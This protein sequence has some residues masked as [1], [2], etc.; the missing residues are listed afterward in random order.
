M[1][2]AIIGAS[3]FLASYLID[4]LGQGHTLTLFSRTTPGVGHAFVPF[5]VPEQPLDPATLLGQDVVIYCAAAGVQAKTPEEKSITQEVNAVLP[6]RLLAYLEEHKWQGKWISF[7]SFW[8]IGTN[9][10]MRGFTEEEIVRSERPVPNLYC[11][12]KRMLSQ[13]IALPSVGV[14]AYHL[15][16][17]TI[18]G[19]RENPNRFIPY[20]IRSLQEGTTPKLSAG[21]QVREYIHATD[22]ASL[23]D[24]IVTGSYPAGIY[25]ASNGERFKMADVAQL[26]FGLFEQ[27]ATPALG[28][29]ETRDESMPVLLLNYD[30]V[31]S[32]IPEWNA[33]VSLKK[34]IKEYLVKEAVSA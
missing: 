24:I 19:V 15:I 7:G 13:Y 5:S 27:D 30:K 4:T 29:L 26:L 20:I 28:T 23:V 31:W 2:I 25:N 32:T 22:V 3:S 6:I 33:K 10:E 21:Q 8:E 18:Y 34:G 17:P 11:E 9:E 1:K 12:S 14:L 16:L